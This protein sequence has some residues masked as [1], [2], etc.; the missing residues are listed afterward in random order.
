MRPA[1]NMSRT[2]RFP[3]LVVLRL[4]TFDSNFAS[5]HKSSWSMLGPP[6]R[7]LLRSAG[8]TEDLFVSR[9]LHVHSNSSIL[10]S[11]DVHKQMARLPLRKS[12]KF[13]KSF[14][15]N[16]TLQSILSVNHLLGFILIRLIFCTPSEVDVMI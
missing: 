13:H 9:K 16:D 4:P 2:T 1:K 3:I 11:E 15:I 6:Y 8:A 12:Y 10:R 14:Q 5:L 7:R